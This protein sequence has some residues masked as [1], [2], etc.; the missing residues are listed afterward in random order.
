ML[1][2]RAVMYVRDYKEFDSSSFFFFFF[3]IE[4]LHPPDIFFCQQICLLRIK[5]KHTADG[6]QV[7]VLTII[8][9]T[10]IRS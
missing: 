7:K 4:L 3:L 6:L 8:Y 1:P 2:P 10:H 9:R 5:L